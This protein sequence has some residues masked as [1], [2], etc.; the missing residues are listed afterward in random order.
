CQ[1][2][3]YAPDDVRIIGAP[4]FDAYLAPDAQWSREALSARLQLDPARP[5]ILFAT[6]GQFSQQI[7]ETNPLE[8]LL[9]AVDSGQIPN[10]PQIVLRM[11][12]WSRD[13]YFAPFIARPD[14]ILSRY[15]TYVP[16]LG[17]SPTRDEVVLAGNLLRHADVIVSPGSTMSIEGAIFDTPT[18]VPVFNEY[19]PEVFDAY[20]QRTWLDQHFS[21]LY[22]R[23]W[24]PVLRSGAAM[25]DAINR[26][27]T[28]P[29]WY[30]EGRRQI[31]D[32]FLGPLDAQA[33]V[34]FAELILSAAGA[35]K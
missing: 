35:G 22:K 10:Q 31:R 15:E 9:R 11:H 28:D 18:V 5:I 20:F 21:Q 2:E 8:V 1:L 19:M 32:T 24:V 33:T 12:P 27:L 7:D 26:A 14:V 4:A 3:A 17:W 13:T 23:D 29:A 6:L 30:T 25:I 16:G 34:R